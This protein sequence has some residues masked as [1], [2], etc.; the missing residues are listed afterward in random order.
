M[1]TLSIMEGASTYKLDALIIIHLISTLTII[2]LDV[3]HLEESC[4][5][6]QNSGDQAID[7]AASRPIAWRNSGAHVKW[8]DEVKALY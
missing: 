7:S 2:G 3:F 4:L 5:Y 8:S 6:S 1:D